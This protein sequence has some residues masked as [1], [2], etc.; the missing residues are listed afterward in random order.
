[1]AMALVGLVVVLPVL[2]V[3]ALGIFLSSPGPVLYRARRIG[4]DR[5]SRPEG[6]RP[7]HLPEKRQGPSRGHEFTLYK[8]RTMRAEASGNG[9]PITARRDSRVFRFG[10]WLRTLKVDELPQL[11]NVV[12]GD[13]AIVGPRPE[14]PDIA[15][16]HYS[17]ADKETLRV[18]PGLTSP[19]SLYYYTHCEPRLTGENASETYVEEVLPLKLALD[20]VY[21]RK[22]TLLYDAQ[23]MGRTIA[24]IVARVMGRRRF[25]PPPELLELA[26]PPPARVSD[27]P[28][29]GARKS[30]T[31]SRT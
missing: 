29:N 10:K 6:G 11:V 12:R 14:D 19:G 5:R 18:P 30:V 25:P 1:M 17:A 3:A 16:N 7:A 20:R 22:A 15:R 26:S 2:L 27:E 4:R 8:L 24:V 21:L 28:A 13:M 31:V 23:I 9:S